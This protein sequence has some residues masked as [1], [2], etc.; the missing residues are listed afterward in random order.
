MTL[1][2][3]CKGLLL[4]Y[5]GTLLNGGS[6]RMLTALGA[7]VAEPPLNATACGAPS[8]TGTVS[9]ALATTPNAI[10]DADCDGSASPI[11]QCQAKKADGTVLG[12][13]TVGTAD[14]DINL[15]TVTYAAHEILRITSGAF[16]L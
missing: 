3:A 11:T 14:C 4:T 2:D 7:Q 9:M 10:E 1:S 5:F 8:G 6:L 16:S 15:S 13:L 12:T